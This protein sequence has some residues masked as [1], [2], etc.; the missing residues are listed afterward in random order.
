M[1]ELP[2]LFEDCEKYNSPHYFGGP[3]CGSDAKT[4]SNI[5]YLN[6]VN[7]KSDNDEVTPEHRGYCPETGHSNVCPWSPLY[8]PICAS[9]NVTYQNLEAMY[10]AANETSEVLTMIK[11]EPCEM[12]DP[13]EPRSS[14]PDEKVCTSVGKTFPNADIVR[15]LRQYH[16]DIHILHSGGCTVK[17]VWDIH[18]SRDKICHLAKEH[19][20]WNPICASDNKMCANPFVF[21]CYRPLANAK[22]SDKCQSNLQK[23]CKIAAEIDAGIHPTN[24]TDICVCG[25]DGITYTS[26]H[27]LN[28]AKIKDRHLY[29]LH[30]GRC[31]PKDSPC[32][33]NTQPL[34]SNEVCG[35]D[36]VTYATPNALYCIT[37]TKD[38]GLHYMHDGP[39]AIKLRHSSK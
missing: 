15:C 19:Y 27:H 30:S 33:H 25:R 32:F 5:F 18:K 17:D 36:G 10:C 39:C 2:V 1:E 14:K 38:K 35:S 28:C 24:D 21:I 7:Y 8:R 26:E 31:T 3:I 11:N 34:D 9:N 37:R 23:S 12:R 16:S 6:C 22:F 20:E 29:K 4:Y 13:C